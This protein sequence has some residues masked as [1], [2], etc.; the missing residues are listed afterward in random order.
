[1]NTAGASSASQLGK[2]W[3]NA[4]VLH[5]KSRA[6]TVILVSTI[7][8]GGHAQN[9]T[10]AVYEKVEQYAAKH[11][12]TRWIYEAIFVPQ[13][14]DEEP[15]AQER[16]RR[17][18]DPN[19]K[20][21]GRTIRRIEVH[22]FDPFGYS[23]DDTLQA[24][25]NGLQRVGNGLHRRSRPRIIRN[26]L[27]VRPLDR[28][29][30]LKVTESERVL[31]ASAIVNDASVRVVRVNG[32]KDSV[33]VIVLVHD[34]WS[35]DAS[36]EGD[37]GSAT[38]TGR[39]RNL[40]GWGQELEQQVTYGLGSSQI[41][42]RGRHSVYN[43]KRSFITS[44]FNY[45]ASEELDQVGLSFARPFYSPLT[46][47][48]GALSAVRSWTN[49][50]LVDPTSGILES[51]Q[52]APVSFNTW[53]ARSYPLGKSPEAAGQ[54]SHF[55]LG[56]RYAQTRFAT[57]PSFDI[58][59]A[60]SNSASSLFLVSAG[61]SVRQYY[62]ER[63]LYRFGATEDVPEGLLCT[64]TAGVRKRELYAPLPYLGLSVSRGRNTD[65]FGYISLA[66]A[67]GTFFQRGQS[68][69]GTFRADLTY[70]TE[71]YTAGRWH[72]REFVR[73]STTVGINKPA[74]T[75]ISLGGDQLYGLQSGGLSGTQ[76]TTLN[77]ETVAYAPYNILGFRFAPVLLLGFGNVGEQGD[78]LLAGRIYSAFSLGLLVRNENL[79]VKTFEV[80]LGFYPYLPDGSTTIIQGN[81]SISYSIRAE[82]FAFP[83]PAIVEY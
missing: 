57:R 22:V 5:R 1:M 53:L 33:D 48:A 52:V 9:D 30:P 41:G 69:D 58:D 80:S 13:V 55:I 71:P 31:R 47:W 6:F 73:I 3:Q 46:R 35:M 42:L 32:T 66:L 29:D 67:F 75:R 14:S 39:D 68:V 64:G 27:L 43:I 7:S 8:L 20:Y 21:K 15:K 4:S 61:I 11:R 16:P 60:R 82:D 65:R 17:R 23:V 19:R 81:P 49:S 50:M 76:R 78:P 2:F 10:T 59:T 12:V 25:T 36:G 28:L 40:L 51:H 62:Q 26:L 18:V 77:L 54:S 63:Y 74:T 79:L 70:F 72:L 24:P 83:Q 56:A 44:T 34:K 45:T 38:L 37:L